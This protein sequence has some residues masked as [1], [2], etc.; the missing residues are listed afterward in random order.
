MPVQGFLLKSPECDNAPVLSAKIPVEGRVLSV[1]RVGLGLWHETAALEIAFTRLL[2]QSGSPIEINGRVKLIDNARETVRKGVIR[3]I[4][5]TDTPQGR[6]T[7]RLKYLPSVHLYPDPFLL[8]YKM[9][10][11]IFPE[12]EINLPP[13]KYNVSLKI[14]SGAVQNREFEIAADETWGLLAGPAGIPLPIHLY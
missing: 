14:A 3:G 2:P 11:P 1:H 6:I 13:G 8:G 9:L 4:R 7:S 10:F 12:P 5:S